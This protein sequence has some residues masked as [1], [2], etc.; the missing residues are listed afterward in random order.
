MSLDAESAEARALEAASLAA[1]G[2]DSDVVRKAARG[3]LRSL[4]QLLPPARVPARVAAFRTRA[5]AVRDADLAAVP[6]WI[7]S[8][9]R[10]NFIKGL[11]RLRFRMYQNQNKGSFSPG[12]LLTETFMS[13]GSGVE[14]Q[15][16]KKFRAV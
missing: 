10:S 2:D 5:G 12:I 8:G 16:K 3:L 13:T 14:V 7:S 6:P 1:L 9:Q 15:R 4:L 11:S